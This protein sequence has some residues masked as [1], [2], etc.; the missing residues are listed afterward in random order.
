M[1]GDDGSILILMP[2]TIIGALLVGTFCFSL[3]RSIRRRRRARIQGFFLGAL[4]GAI[5]GCG[6]GCVLASMPLLASGKHFLFMQQGGTAYGHS[7]CAAGAAMRI[8]LITNPKSGRN[9]GVAAAEA[10][11]REF[12]RGGWEVV[13]RLTEGPG[14]AIRLAREAAGEGFDAVFAC[15]GDGTLS[16]V[17]AGLLDTGVPGGTIPA[18]TG[19]DFARTIGLSRD[20]AAAARQLVEGH[21]EDIDL[22][23]IDDGSLWGVNVVGVGFDAAVAE[24]INRRRRLTGGPLAYLTGIAQQMW[25]YCPTELR[26]R[27]GD[28]EWEGQALLLAIGNAQSYGGG[29]KIAPL[30]AIDDGLLDVVLVEHV[31]RTRFLCSLPRVFRGTHVDLPFV[32]MWQ[33]REVTIEASQ[34]SP[35]LVDGDVQC[36]TPLHIRV[37]EGRGKLWMPGA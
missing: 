31:S 27:V 11:E 32:R 34:P 3:E 7:E 28:E 20:C 35:A 1:T 29:M 6:V 17:M 26:L 8:A 21:A 24:R 13:R 33:A 18:G 2:C 22:L 16:Q 9:S 30:A 25:S 37:S 36:E 4:A 14:D 19:N 5:A 10:G 12:R 15:G 23:D